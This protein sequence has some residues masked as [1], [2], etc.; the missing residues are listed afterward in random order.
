M[1]HP[2]LSHRTAV[3][4]G[5]SSRA[6]SL[7]SRLLQS[8]VIA[9]MALLIFGTVL[10]LMHHGDY[11][12]NPDALEGVTGPDAEFPHS[13]AELPGELAAF[14]GRAYVV[15]GLLVLILTP[16]LRV[17]ASVV[18]FIR[19]RDWLFAAMTSLVLVI[20]IVSFLLG[21]TH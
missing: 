19:Q 1:N 14:K 5:A 10:T 3:E 6:E 8:G 2:P 9:S 17:A 21:K 12:S 15:L 16:V 7:L 11:F 18:L 4:A 20:L 13:L